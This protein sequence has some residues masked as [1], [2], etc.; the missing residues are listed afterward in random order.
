MDNEFIYIQKS[1]IPGAGNGVF[2]KKK[3]KSGKKL[4]E[5]IGKYYKINNN[6]DEIYEIINKNSGTDEYVMAINDKKGDIYAL[7]DGYDNGNWITMINGA[8]TKEQFNYINCE[9]YQ[10]NKRMYLKTTK[11][12]QK[13]DELIIDYGDR[14]VWD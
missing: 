5:Y 4:G 10:Y 13:N 14:Y 9:F 2:S 3:I 12:I 6:I 11:E 8:K 1:K 7:I